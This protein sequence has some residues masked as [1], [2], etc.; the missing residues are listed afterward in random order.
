[1]IKGKKLAYSPDGSV[2]FLSNYSEVAVWNIRKS[3]WNISRVRKSYARCPGVLLGISLDNHTFMTL[4]GTR[5]IAVWNLL[6]GKKLSIKDISSETYELHQRAIISVNKN[7]LSFT[8][9]DIFGKFSFPEFQIPLKPTE[10]SFENWGIAPNNKI[11]SVAV[12]GSAGGF[13]WANGYSFDLI[14]GKIIYN[15]KASDWINPAPF[16]FSKHGFLI[17]GGTGYY[18]IYD[19]ESGKHYSEVELTSKSGYKSP[20]GGWVVDVHPTNKYLFAYDSDMPEF[21]I[22]IVE[23]DLSGSIKEVAILPES[24][25]VLDIEFHPDGNHLACLLRNGAIHIWDINKRKIVRQCE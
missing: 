12:G 1:M 14:S 22:Q 11:V 20:E 2:I 17:S 5:T 9:T 18:H 8:V 19:L 21:C 24:D 3:L 4:Q 16:F 15:F 6:S 7:N 10:A 13:D 25:K 23:I